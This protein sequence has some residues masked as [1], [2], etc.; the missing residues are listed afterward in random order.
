MA[1]SK[2]LPLTSLYKVFFSAR[3]ILPILAILSLATVVSASSTSSSTSYN[4]EQ[5]IINEVCS[6]YHIIDT[7][8]FV[9]ALALIVL[10]GTIYA[11]SHA[12]GGM[13]GTLQGYAMGLIL[14]G[15]IGVIIVLLAAPILNIVASVGNTSFSVA[16]AC[17][18]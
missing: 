8:I 16:T 10:G 18:S 11:V 7:V 17:A 9:I 14:G 5:T 6:I 2:L 15:I 12:T 13:K 4:A 3:L 1:T